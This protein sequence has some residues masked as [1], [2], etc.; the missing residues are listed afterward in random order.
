MVQLMYGRKSACTHPSSPFTACIIPPES[1]D[2]PCLSSRNQAGNL[3]TQLQNAEALLSS[4]KEGELG[5]AM[6][7]ENESLKLQVRF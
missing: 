3:R 2:P 5:R 6:Q 1:S 7:D 4:T